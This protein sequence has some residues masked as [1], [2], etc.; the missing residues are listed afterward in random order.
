MINITDKKDCIGCYAC[1]NACPKNCID[2]ISDYEGFKYPHIDKD[3]CIECNLCE[4]VC[5]II[6]PKTVN[7]NPFAIACYNKNETI[8]K[9]SSSGGIFSLLAEEVIK[10]NGIVFGARFDENF[11]VIHDYTNSIEGLNKFRGSKYVQSTIGNTYKQVKEFLREGKIVLFSGTPCQIGGLKRYL[12]NDYENLICL[13]LICHGVPSS[14]AWNK[15]KEYMSGGKKIEHINFRNKTYGW[16]SYSVSFKFQN[17][18]EILSKGSE[19]KYIRGFIGDIYLRPS[20]HD[21][22][23]KTLNRES[24]ITLADFWG[25]DKL[26]TDMNDNKGTSLIFINSEKGERIFKNI[27][28]NIVM[29]EVDINE[30]VKYNLSAIKP[31]YCNPRRNYFFKRIDKQ[32]FEKLVINSLKDPLDIR[33]KIKISKL[34]KFITKRS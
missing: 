34:I 26:L 19:D 29:K 12:Q 8:R 31:S 18:S 6:H 22:K 21:C 23:F 11:N 28:E 15:Y 24:D 27:S 20:C 7:N 10:N 1:A 25:A 2:M 13:D 4:K 5:P 32:N 9:A 3:R 33:I 17:G 30:A 16:E 14:K